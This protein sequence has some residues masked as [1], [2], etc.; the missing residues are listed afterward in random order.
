MCTDRCRCNARVEYIYVLYRAKSIQVLC[1]YYIYIDDVIAYYL[2]LF[3]VCLTLC[4]LEDT[5]AK[6]SHSVAHAKF[7]AFMIWSLLNLW[8]DP[9]TVDSLLVIIA[10]MLLA[11]GFKTPHSLIK[12]AAHAPA[13][14]TRSY[15]SVICSGLKTRYNNLLSLWSL[16][17]V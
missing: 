10:G 12:G 16:F 2:L 6:W 13:A 9:S 1:F 17:R 3:I 5:V 15:Y 11:C 4:T 8:A 14:R 7:F